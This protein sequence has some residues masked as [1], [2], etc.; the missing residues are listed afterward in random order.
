MIE[1]LNFYG[2]TEVQRELERIVGVVVVN[3]NT[4]SSKI[5]SLYRNICA[6]VVPVFIAVQGVDQTLGSIVS[7]AGNGQEIIELIG[8]EETGISDSK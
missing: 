3:R 7:I 8:G 2:P 4:S 1:N 5:F 6:A